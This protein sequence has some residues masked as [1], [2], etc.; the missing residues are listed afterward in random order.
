MMLKF[1]SFLDPKVISWGLN[2][3]PDFSFLELAFALYF[4]GLKNILASPL[5]FKWIAF[6]VTPIWK[7]WFL[8]KTFVTGTMA[9][10]ILN[11]P[12]CSQ[13]TGIFRRTKI[14]YIL[15][16]HQSDSSNLAKLAKM[17]LLGQK[18]SKSSF[19]TYRNIIITK[20]K[21]IGSLYIF[22]FGGISCKINTCWKMFFATICNLPS[23]EKMPFVQHERTFI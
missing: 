21:Q 6:S 16:M 2:T 5:F 14:H 11:L 13:D 1:P 15:K 17:D 4:F 20:R 23:I 10:W 3:N 19:L 22:K 12:I 7:F 8:C 9:N 18:L